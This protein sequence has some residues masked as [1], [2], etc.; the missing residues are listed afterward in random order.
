MGNRS[1][2]SG[3]EEARDLGCS[4][5]TSTRFW[6]V[7]GH[8][9]LLRHDELSG[10]RQILVDQVL[11]DESRKV[12]DDGS[13]H[14]IAVGGRPATLTISVVK[15]GFCYNLQIGDADLGDVMTGKV[16]KSEDIHVQ[17]SAASVDE[18]DQAVYFTV[19]SKTPPC[20]LGAFEP[21]D[22]RTVRR[23]FK[24]FVALDAAVRSSFPSKHLLSSFP[25]LP[26]R[27]LKLLT[28][29]KSHGEWHR[30]CGIAK[31]GVVCVFVAVVAASHQL[32][33]WP[34]PCFCCDDGGDL[35][36]GCAW[37]YSY[38]VY[39]E[40]TRGFA[41]ILDCLDQSPSRRSTTGPASFS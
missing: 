39:G 17:L 24:D 37:L 30:G 35:H 11:C 1:S 9:V 8:L 3:S 28:D 40:A 34:L 25:R 16:G 19:D 10:L 41:A 5:N 36:V 33:S 6:Y 2:Q 4:S 26:P 29:H 7:D 32:S 14:A 15:L 27:H 12:L 13:S 23:R 18:A 31:R 21:D 20:Q 22:T 38:R